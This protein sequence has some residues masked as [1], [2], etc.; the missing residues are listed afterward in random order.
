[1]TAA[2]D[3]SAFHSPWPL[4]TATVIDWSHR[5]RRVASKHPEVVDKLVI[6]DFA[7]CLTPPAALSS[8]N[9]PQTVLDADLV[10]YTAWQA[11]SFAVPSRVSPS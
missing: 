10:D 8:L 7:R 1:M 2:L 4:T 3:E 9:D 6:I 5:H 11:L